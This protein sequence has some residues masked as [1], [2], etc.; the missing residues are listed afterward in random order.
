MEE[1]QG[2]KN[3]V[4]NRQNSRVKPFPRLGDATADNVKGILRPAI[5]GQTYIICG[6]EKEISIGKVTS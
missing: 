5:I 4:A 3:N 2:K 1:T 6:P